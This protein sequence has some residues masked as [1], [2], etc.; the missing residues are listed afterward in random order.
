AGFN[1][2]TML[3]GDEWKALHAPMPYHAPPPAKS[4]GGASYVLRAAGCVLLHAAIMRM[5]THC[6]VTCT[7]SALRVHEF[8]LVCCREAVQQR[9]LAKDRLRGRSLQAP[10]TADHRIAGA[11]QPIAN[12][13]SC[14]ASYAFATAAVMEAYFFYANADDSALSAQQLVDCT[15]NVGNSGCSG[16]SLASTLEWSTAYAL[17]TANDYPWV[18]STQTCATSCTPVVQGTG[19]YYPTSETDLRDQTVISVTAGVV[20]FS[21]TD[22]QNYA[23]G[24][25]T[26]SCSSSSS[27][28]NTAVALVGYGT[29]G[30][31]AYW[32]VRNS[33]GTSWGMYGYMHLLRGVNK[34]GVANQPAAMS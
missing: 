9:R 33:R 21:T 25:F 8:M 19:V 12:Q 20:D 23:S 4:G 30:S 31:G 26:G 15:S 14:G 1:E 17:C 29:S 24:V 10:S 11:V 6:V 3:T 2:Y 13:G 18:G 34:C 5:H 27:A 32:V 22:V 28:G 7:C 16:G